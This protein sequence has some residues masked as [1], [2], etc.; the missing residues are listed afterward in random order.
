MYNEKVEEY[1]FPN[2]FEE[3]KQASKEGKVIQFNLCGDWTDWDNPDFT[4]DLSDYRIK[5]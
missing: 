5:R 4:G 3:L 1:Y 2:S